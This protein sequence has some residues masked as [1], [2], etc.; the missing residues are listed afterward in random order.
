MSVSSSW[1]ST[2][3]EEAYTYYILDMFVNGGEWDQGTGYGP[4]PLSALKMG[5]LRINCF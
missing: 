2:G 4:I 3:R 1:V 5:S